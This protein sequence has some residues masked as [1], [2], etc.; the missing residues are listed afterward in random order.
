MAI[1][2]NCSRLE[3]TWQNQVNSTLHFSGMQLSTNINSLQFQMRMFGVVLSSQMTS[4]LLCKLTL[5]NW[6]TW[7]H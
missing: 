1:L 7:A 2:P 3:S 4:V 6:W 5:V